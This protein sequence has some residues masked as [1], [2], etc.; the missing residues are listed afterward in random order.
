LPEPDPHR[1]DAPRSRGVL[2]LARTAINMQFR[3]VYPF[4]PAI[5]RGL[6]VPLETAS[7]LLAVRS[8]VALGSP[9]Y[10]SLAD[11]IG[12]RP[13]MFIGLA[14]LILGAVLVG[15]T[16]VFGLAVIAF[17][18]FGFS[19]SSY[20]PAMYAYVGD[21]VPYERRGRVTGILEL[22][23]A[24]A[25]LIGVPLAGFLITRFS[26]RAPY[27]FIA[28]AGVASVLVLWRVCPTCGRSPQHAPSASAAPRFSIRNLAWL[29]ILL[30]ALPALTVTLLLMT[31][32][33]NVFVVYGAW[34]ESEFG[35]AV[36][37]IGVISIVISLAELAA[38]GT[39]AGIVD[40][41]GKRRSVL[42]GLVFS[43]L[44]YLV[45]PRLAVNLT[46]AIAGVTLMILAFE[47]S[48]VSL[49]PLVT[50]VVPAAR[51][52]VVALNVAA[53]SLGRIIATLMST[54]LWSSGGLSA[55]A[56]V[57][58]AIMLAALAVL[59]FAVRER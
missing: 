59:I 33:E 29:R 25:W 23:W 10:G 57:S 52:T 11:R 27:W 50:E 31:A 51:G 16:P 54:R 34:L 1:P 22:P 3:I 47:F 44:T 55:N 7:L 32:S 56:R 12:R 41:L 37:A 58:A 15:V 40:R 5:A 8:F 14:A 53:M 2:L 19:K 6:G 13:V 9:L 36:G 35:L 45:L 21:A 17:A 48:I 18:L 28:A 43:L 26:W 30:P 4:L 38:E 24:L 49:V 46:G 42:G 39:S 20:D